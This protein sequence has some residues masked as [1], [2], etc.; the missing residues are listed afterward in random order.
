[1]RNMPHPIYL[2]NS[3]VK[4]PLFLDLWQKRFHHAARQQLLPACGQ[5][6]HPTCVAPHYGAARAHSCDGHVNI[7]PIN[8]QT[9]C[10]QI[11]GTTL[12]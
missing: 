6:R 8:S 12:D 10:T 4:L 11:S 1:M 3:L 9:A 5:L 2:L 7:K